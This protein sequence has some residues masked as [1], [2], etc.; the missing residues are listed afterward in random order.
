MSAELLTADVTGAS[1]TRAAASKSWWLFSP[2]AD[3]CIFGGSALVSLALLLLGARAGVLDS[4]SPDWTWVPA[5]LLVDVA[6]VYATGFRVY[7]DVGELKRRAGLYCLAPL[8]ALALGVARSR[9]EQRYGFDEDCAQI[10]RSGIPRPRT[11]RALQERVL[12]R[13]DVRNGWRIAYA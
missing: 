13:R 11:G 12:W 10:D 8:V 9:M 5:V 3:V 4:E 2:R 1:A 7:F 6:H